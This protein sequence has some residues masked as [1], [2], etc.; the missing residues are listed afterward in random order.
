VRSAKESVSDAKTQGKLGTLQ[1]DPKLHSLLQLLIQ[2]FHAESEPEYRRD[3]HTVRWVILRHLD[4]ALAG[5][6]EDGQI[7]ARG[8]GFHNSIQGQFN[9]KICYSL[10]GDN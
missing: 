10:P 4:G 5:V 1:Y 8:C 3:G 6:L 2:H 9:L 7:A